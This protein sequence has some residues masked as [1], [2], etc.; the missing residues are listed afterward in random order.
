MRSKSRLP[1]LV[2]CLLGAWGLIAGVSPAAAQSQPEDGPLTDPGVVPDD[3]LTL[4]VGT[5]FVTAPVSE[6]SLKAQFSNARIPMAAFNETDTCIDR[7]ALEAAQDYFGTL[8]RA[9]GKA[10][11]YYLVPDEDVAE[12]A[13]ACATSHGQPA[14]AWARDKIKIIAFGRVV[15]T[16]SAAALEESIR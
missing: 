7:R 14:K 11:Y 16:D 3:L 2:A 5:R 13:S 8:G 9:L 4:V 10:G 6:A 12:F 1:L 15:P